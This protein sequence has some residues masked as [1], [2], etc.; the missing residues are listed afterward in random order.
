LSFVQK[1]FP[2]V[3]REQYSG[4]NG[5]AA[6][7]PTATRS[8]IFVNADNSK[9]VTLTVD[10]YANGRDALAAYREAVSKSKIPGFAPV[11]V[12]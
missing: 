3:I 4:G 5:T 10:H 11:T 8:V 6:G 2:Q 12:R 9:K 7:N 1:Y